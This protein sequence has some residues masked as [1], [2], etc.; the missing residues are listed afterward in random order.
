MKIVRWSRLVQ[1][2]AKASDEEITKFALVVFDSKKSG[3]RKQGIFINSEGEEVIKK[4]VYKFED[5]CYTFSSN[6]KYFN[7][8]KFGN[9]LFASCLR[10]YDSN[11]INLDLYLVNDKQGWQIKYAFIFDDE[12]ELRLFR[13]S[14]RKSLAFEIFDALK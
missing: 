6:E 14:P 10:G 9:S 12:N 3:W 2:F 7:G 8:S 4:I 1:E 11:G 13:A 5:C